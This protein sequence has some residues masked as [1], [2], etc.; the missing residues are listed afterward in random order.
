MSISAEKKQEII[1]DYH[2]HD[3]DTGSADVQV[4]IL[5]ERI[6]NITNHLKVFK[7]DHHCKRGLLKLVSQR[8]K[9]L[10]YIKNQSLEKYNNLIKRLGIR[11]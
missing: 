2:L 3:A 7:K 11:K 10:L 6:A 8:R 4:A 1:K 9:L 5:T